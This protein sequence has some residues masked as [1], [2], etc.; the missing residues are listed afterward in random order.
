MLNGVDT[1]P[2]NT[3]VDIW[4]YKLENPKYIIQQEHFCLS[5]PTIFRRVPFQT[6]VTTVKKQEVSVMWPWAVYSLKASLIQL[7]AMRE[8][9]GAEQVV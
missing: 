8:P 1:Q 4:Y 7:I 5:Q 6:L 9:F 3:A 2:I